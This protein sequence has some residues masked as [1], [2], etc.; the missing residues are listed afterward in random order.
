MNFLKTEEKNGYT[1]L[2]LD[3]GTANVLNMEMVLEI[4]GWFTQ[5]AENEECGGVIL[6]GKG[7]F[8]SAGLDVV[9]LYSY[10]EEESARFWTAFAKMTET[11]ASFPRPLICAINGHS[12]AGGC[13]MAI[14][15]DWRVMSRGKFRIGLN[16]V[17]VGIAVP[18]PIFLLYSMWI[19][20]RNAYQYLLEGKLLLPEEAYQTGLIDVLCEQEEVLAEAEKKM[21]VYLSMDSLTFRKTKLGLR[22]GILRSFREDFDDSFGETIRHWWTP[23][24]RGRIKALVESLKK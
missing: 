24:A 5:A 15:S 11:L 20:R 21:H 9:E 14:A 17:P 18:E 2:H 8:F 6:Y 12:P 3:R 1:I 4:I 7:N 19:G 23:G 16:E 22:R 13:I 10:N